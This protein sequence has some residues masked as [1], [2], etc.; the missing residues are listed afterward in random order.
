MSR[1]KR[2]KKEKRGT[3]SKRIEIKKNF[4]RKLIGF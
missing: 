1:E 2:G 3:V 4:F